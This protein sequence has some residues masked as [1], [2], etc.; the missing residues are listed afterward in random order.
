M[1]RRI[2]DS[3]QCERPA[4]A[5]VSCCRIDYR[6][7]VGTNLDDRNVSKRRIDLISD[8]ST[9]K[10]CELHLHELYSLHLSKACRR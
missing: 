3:N 4:S 5:S 7:P 1:K 6:L 9:Q 10:L 8:Y 2:Y